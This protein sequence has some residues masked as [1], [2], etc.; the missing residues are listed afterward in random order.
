MF[1]QKCGKELIEGSAFCDS[2]GNPVQIQ[3][4]ATNAESTSQVYTNHTNTTIRRSKPWYKRW[5][6][7]TIAVVVLFFILTVIGSNETA[8]DVQTV[9]RVSLSQ[10][11]TNEAEGISFK[12][13]SAWKVVPDTSWNEYYDESELENVMVVLENGQKN[14]ENYSLLEIMKFASDKA[15]IDKIFSATESDFTEA[16]SEETTINLLSD[17]SLDGVPARM[18]VYTMN[19]DECCRRYY[20]AVGNTM[21]RVDF[22]YLASQAE[23][24]GRFF[25][26]IMESYKIAVPENLYPD[27]ILYDGV[28]IAQIFQTSVK[29]ISKLLGEPA[30]VKGQDA[31][32]FYEP[33]EG[34]EGAE[35]CLS[36]NL[37][38]HLNEITVYSSNKFTFNGVSLGG[39]TRGELVDLL[40]APDSQS[41]PASSRDEYFM[42]WQ[43]AN[44]SVEIVMLSAAPEETVSVTTFTNNNWIPD[45][46]PSIEPAT[47]PNMINENFEWVE[48]PIM[49]A[50]DWGGKTISG[51]IR[52]TS[53]KAF[54]HVSISFTLYDSEG[55]QVGTAFTSIDNLAEGN[56]WKFEAGVIYDSATQFRLA[57][58]TTY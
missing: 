7:W 1:C 10:N 55:N 42:N 36:Y 4:E 21:Y 46:M 35:V 18:L 19:K 9:D 38:G 6:I 33:I 56:T 17:I 28:P 31:A 50:N 48:R 52:N 5:W 25:D 11:Y 3:R 40:G 30:E 37:Q 53:A 16:F 27:E 45:P 14:Q 57:D 29:D 20:Y 58:I 12:Y 39:K 49:R 8:F 26:A 32:Y 54:S 23:S 44:Y 43:Q 51:I 2:C 24:L 47:N 41:D 15:E 22:L 13:P 34:S